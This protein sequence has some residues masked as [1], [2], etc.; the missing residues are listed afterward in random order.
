[1]RIQC[2][3]VEPTDQYDVFLRRF[4]FSSDGTCP[5]GK[6]YHEALV[7]LERLD[8]KDTRSYNNKLEAAVTGDFWPHD[9][10]RWP[11]ECKCGFKFRV[12]DEWQYSPRAVY[13]RADTGE[14]ALLKDFQAGAMWRSPWLEEEDSHMTGS[15]GASWSVRTPDGDWLIDGRASNCTL[16]QDLRHKCWIRH[17]E[18]PLFTANKDGYS[19]DAGA[20]S[21]VSGA[22]HGFLRAGYLERC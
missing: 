9:D 14:L 15:D 22:Y 2:F 5:H 6:G 11:A 10:A 8:K 7:L 17:G 20:G 21:I 19:C 3:V 12:W 4:S 13:K 1:M 16:P 18:A